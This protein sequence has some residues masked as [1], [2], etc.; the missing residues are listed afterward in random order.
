[1]AKQKLHQANTNLIKILTRHLEK[2]KGVNR[3]ISEN[4]D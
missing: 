1:M 2:E 3:Y 4:Y